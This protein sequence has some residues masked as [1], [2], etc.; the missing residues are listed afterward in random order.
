[1]ERLAV[2]II[3]TKL[4]ME[5]ERVH[6]LDTNRTKLAQNGKGTNRNETERNGRQWNEKDANLFTFLF[7]YFGLKKSTKQ[8][9]R[10]YMKIVVVVVK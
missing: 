6:Q 2:G 3:E 1:M 7:D 10:Q 9:I 4:Q 8:N 5:K